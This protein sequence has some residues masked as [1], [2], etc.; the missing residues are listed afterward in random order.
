MVP[1]ETPA[2]VMAMPRGFGR[3]LAETI[4]AIDSDDFH[5][6][7]IEGL[8][9]MIPCDFWIVARYE[10]RAEPLIISDTGMGRDAR[11]LYAHALWQLDPLPRAAESAG[12]RP[13]SLG[14]IRAGGALDHAYDA[15]LDR[16]L[17]IRDELALLF[18][19]NASSFLALCLDRRLSSFSPAEVALA[20]ELQAI[21][22]ET[23]RQ[24][25]QRRIG[26]EIA[27]LTREMST[28]EAEVLVLSHH[29]TVLFQSAAWGEAAAEAFGV[30]PALARIGR[31]GVAMTVGRDGWSL[32]RLGSP[33]RGG[34]LADAT[35]HVLRRS[36]AERDDRLGRFARL[37][38]LT[39]RQ[40]QIVA[41]ALEGHPNAS[42]ARSL[43]LTVGGVKNHKL[44]IYQKL[45]ITSERELMAAVL[46][47]A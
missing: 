6:H 22:L 2:A 11:D 9:Q 4:H 45:D 10:P 37:H 5:L 17:G 43:N 12:L 19:L 33:S 47:H 40:R 24:H 14:G 41:L 8:R 35:I 20:E 39:T 18:P 29:G 25:V 30:A 3:L 36:R 42:I 26:Q 13:V 1:S 27:F 44:R 32:T 21:L 34:L 16:T 7:M 46:H 28:S 23:H 31:G 38:G 15:Y